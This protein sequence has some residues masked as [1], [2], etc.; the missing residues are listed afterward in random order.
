MKNITSLWQLLAAMDKKKLLL[1]RGSQ[2]TLTSVAAV[3]LAGLIKEAHAQVLDAKSLD[4]PSAYISDDQI[5]QASIQ[6]LPTNAYFDTV[7]ATSIKQLPFTLDFS[8]HDSNSKEGDVIAQEAR[9]AML[10]VQ[11]EDEKVIE[12]FVRHF[13]DTNLGPEF[14]DLSEIIAQMPEP[15]EGQAIEAAYGEELSGHSPQDSVTEQAKPEPEVDPEDIAKD[16]AASSENYKPSGKGEA[17]PETSNAV[18]EGGSNLLMIGGIVGGLGAAGA[19]A[20]AA[21]GGGSNDPE[22][23]PEPE[24]SGPA[25]DTTPPKVTVSKKITADVSPELVGTVDDESAR[26]VVEIDGQ[27]YEATNKGNGTWVLTKGTIQPGL[28]DG[29]YSIHVT[30]TD[31]AGNQGVENTANELI[32]DSNASDLAVNNLL[33]NDETPALSGEVSDPI[34]A[35]MVTVNGEEYTANNNSDGTWSLPDDTVVQLGQDGVYWVT[36]TSIDGNGNRSFGVGEVTLDTVRPHLTTESFTTSDVTP[37]MSGAIDDPSATVTVEVFNQT[38]S[39]TYTAHNDTFGNWFLREEDYIGKQSIPNGLAVYDVKVIAEDPAGNQGFGFSKLNFDDLPPAISLDTIPLTNDPTYTFTGEVND[40]LATLTLNMKGLNVVYDQT[41]TFSNPGTGFWDFTWPQAVGD[42][43]YE[44]TFIGTDPYGNSAST[45]HVYDLDT[46]PADITMEYARDYFGEGVINTGDPLNFLLQGTVS[47]IG[48]DI[49]DDAAGTDLFIDISGYTG[50]FTDEPGGGI[51]HDLANSTWYFDHS[52]LQ[53]VL[54]DG[55]YTVQLT[56]HDD[57]QNISSVERKLI[58]DTVAPTMS[59]NQVSRFNQM[60][61]NQNE[62]YG[63]QEGA[64]YTNKSDATLAGTYIEQFIDTMK[65]HVGNIEYNYNID[66]GDEIVVNAD[67]TWNLTL[68]AA[69]YFDNIG[70]TQYDVLMEITDINGVSFQDSATLIVDQLKP[71]VTLQTSAGFDNYHYYENGFNVNSETIRF[72]VNVNEDKYHGADWSDFQG[73]TPATFPHYETSATT[74]GFPNGQ[75][76]GPNAGDYGFQLPGPNPQYGNYTT[77]IKE[78]AIIDYAGNANVQSNT[79]TDA[80]GNLASD[81][82]ATQGSANIITTDFNLIT[83]IGI[84][85]SNPDLLAAWEAFHGSVFGSFISIAPTAT[86]VNISDYWTNTSFPEIHANDSH[87]QDLSF[88]SASGVDAGSLMHVNTTSNLEYAN[89]GLG[90]HVTN[91]GQHILTAGDS[92]QVQNT[93]SVSKVFE[94]IGTPFTVTAD[95]SWTTTVYFDYSSEAPVYDGFSHGYLPGVNYRPALD[96]FDLTIH[97]SG[98]ATFDI[99]GVDLKGSQYFD[100]VALNFVDPEGDAY[101]STY[102]VTTTDLFDIS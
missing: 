74:D 1:K 65:V 55:E 19:V 44:M 64:F 70:G 58:V 53:N 85:S 35:V 46:H 57:H 12:N 66:G 25:L 89:G 87:V 23:T 82:V 97:K 11:P 2:F 39:E 96:D 62:L 26:V 84:T 56:A 16:T 10:P 40:P 60:T 93:G 79:I 83:P 47:D 61:N 45:S 20:F 5:T 94:V 15:E 91:N 73:S 24:A 76:L 30:A 38:F 8:K 13:D 18:V 69:Q 81:V 36:A 100:G 75:F 31:A 3:V 71:V 27:E 52:V 49:I 42:G 32:I 90:I 68:E 78:G 21:S 86:Y 14:D 88:S 59:L 43:I 72:S 7:S 29:I 102:Q 48:L 28:N 37:T 98:L 101:F 50:T 80:V 41:E 63:L 95:Y 92:I 33:T 9:D 54:P 51:V 17:V 77:N 34:A 22:P 4:F 6:F 67:G 99:T